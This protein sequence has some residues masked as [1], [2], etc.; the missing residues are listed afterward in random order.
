MPISL[1]KW[2]CKNKY[3]LC[4]LAGSVTVRFVLREEEKQQILFQQNREMWK[5]LWY[6]EVWT[7]RSW[8]KWTRK[9]PL[10]QA[11]PSLCLALATSGIFW[12]WSQGSPQEVGTQGLQGPVC[13]STSGTWAG[14]WHMQLGSCTARLGWQLCTQQAGSEGR[15]G[16]SC[17]GAHLAQPQNWALCFQG[18]IC[19]WDLPS[20][21]TWKQGGVRWHPRFC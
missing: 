21:V 13:P 16:S 14:I 6:S 15:C 18:Y 11:L 4:F 2:R 5:F 10:N 9:L 7:Q 20:W 3:K 19:P 17:W 8:N 12:V 1:C